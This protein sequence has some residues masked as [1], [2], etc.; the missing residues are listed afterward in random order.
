MAKDLAARVNITDIAHHT[1]AKGYTAP[2]IEVTLQRKPGVGRIG[3]I[4]VGLVGQ[5][6][7]CC[8]LEIG[9]RHAHG[10]VRYL[11]GR[12]RFGGGL[13]SLILGLA[14]LTECAWIYW[15]K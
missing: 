12:V 15:T 10:E 3:G 5:H 4:D 11:F 8:F 13:C 9:R 6:C 2:V 1:R 7:L 14:E